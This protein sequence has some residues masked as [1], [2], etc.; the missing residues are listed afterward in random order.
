[1]ALGSDYDI[2]LTIY[3]RDYVIPSIVSRFDPPTVNIY[4]R[5]S[6]ESLR[7]V[8]DRARERAVAIGREALAG[9]SVTKDPA[10]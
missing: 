5:L 10:L 2:I 9:P 7:L 1:M 3:A 8:K 4:I 6:T